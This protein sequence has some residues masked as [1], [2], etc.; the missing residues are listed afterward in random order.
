MHGELPHYELPTVENK[1]C[2][3]NNKK[4]KFLY[5]LLP[6]PNYY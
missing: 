2:R 6:F 5:Y 3:N 4:W 1:K